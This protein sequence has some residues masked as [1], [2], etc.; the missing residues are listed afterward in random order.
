MNNKKISAYFIFGIL[1]IWHILKKFTFKLKSNGIKKFKKNY[2]PE[3]L[4]EI[5]QESYE[6]L[7]EFE[8]CINCSLCDAYC[9]KLTVLHR[10]GL[11]R[12]SELILSS[13]GSIE[14]FR[15]SDNELEVFDNCDD[16][17]APCITICPNDYPIFDLLNMM[18]N[19]NKDLDEKLGKIEGKNE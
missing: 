10:D 17:V 7:S 11:P 14:E 3:Y 1:F 6:K 9:S 5:P 16:C 8:A 13:S 4:I 12:I 19:Y 18:K 2:Y 15:F